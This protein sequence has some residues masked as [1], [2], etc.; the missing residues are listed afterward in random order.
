MYS[1]RFSYIVG[2]FRVISLC[3]LCFDV[4][5]FHSRSSS[6]EGTLDDIA[7]SYIIEGLKLQFQQD[8]S[9]ANSVQNDEDLGS[10][11]SSEL[12]NDTSGIGL[13]ENQDSVSEAR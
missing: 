1:V 2:F 3:F 4:L 8:L 7:E 6:V 5:N 11:S 9:H 12:L 10:K 13:C